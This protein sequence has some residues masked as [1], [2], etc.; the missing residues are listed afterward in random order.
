MKA[1]YYKAFKCAMDSIC[2]G[3][4]SGNVQTE[5]FHIALNNISQSLKY[6]QIVLTFWE[7]GNV[8]AKRYSL[9]KQTNKQTVSQNVCSAQPPAVSRP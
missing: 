9:N 6:S 4:V 7:K 1:E 5:L 2:I 3:S 8:C